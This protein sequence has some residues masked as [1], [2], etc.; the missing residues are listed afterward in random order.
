M[1]NESTCEQCVVWAVS[2]AQKKF[3]CIT[4]MKFQPS[5]EL[6]N[7]MDKIFKRLF[8]YVPKMWRRIFFKNNGGF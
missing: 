4:C 1:I 6:Y 5:P 2:W 7:N 3:L 8:P